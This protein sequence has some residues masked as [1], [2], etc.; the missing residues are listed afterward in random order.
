MAPPIDQIE[1]VESA[2]RVTRGRPEQWE[3]RLVTGEYFH[4]R[5]RFGRATLGISAESP[6]AAI[7]DTSE[8]SLAFGDFWEGE[9]LSDE[10]RT[11]V[12]RL[13]LFEKLA[14]L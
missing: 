5:Y 9:F 13:L 3:G 1:Y 12:F 4:F 2:V 6:D 10:V 7:M 8:A 11:S 14:H